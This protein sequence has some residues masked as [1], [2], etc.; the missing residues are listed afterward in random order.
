MQAIAPGKVILSGEHA[1]VYGAP[2]L[3]VATRCHIHARF[4]PHSA[5]AVSLSGSLLDS[6]Y[7]LSSLGPLKAQLDQRFDAFSADTLAIDAV[8]DSP[9]QLIAYVLASQQF[10]CSGELRLHSELPTGAGMGS[11]AAAIAVTLV[12]ADALMQ[13]QGGQ[14]LSAEQRFTLIRYCERLQH[15]RGSAIDA[16]AV[17]FGGLVRV[18]SDQVTALDCGLGEGWYRVNTGTP[19]ISTGHCVQQVRSKFAQSAIWADFHQVTDRLQ[20]ALG[21][22]D[23]VHAAVRHNHRLLQRIGV[24]PTAVAGFIEAAERLGA[25]AK[26]SG[27]GAVAGD[28]GGQVLLYAP[29]LDVSPLCTA[30]NYPYFP[31]Q[32]DPQGARRISD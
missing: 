30:F 14:P 13:Q 9:D 3:A 17:T 29:G 31:L 10:C 8:L 12:M 7:S 6:A 32:E 24:V 5:D 23:L 19:S 18:E 21:Q 1:V 16:A 22:P 15:G 2:A 20:A 11:S 25:S 28:C 27:A 26:I 4:T